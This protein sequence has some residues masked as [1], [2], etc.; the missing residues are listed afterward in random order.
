MPRKPKYIAEPHKYMKDPRGTF[1]GLYASQI[2]SPAFR[3]LSP[4]QQILFVHMR[5]QEHTKDHPPAEFG[6]Y[7]FYFPRKLWR[8]LLKLYD[9]DERF[10]RDVDGLI[11]KG[12]VDCVSSGYLTKEKSVY[13]F[14]ERWKVYGTDGYTVPANVRRMKVRPKHPADG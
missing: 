3:D 2:Q 8:D 10:Y 5:L 11:E 9:H 6:P 13:R 4:R 12:F 7:T 14:S 1:T